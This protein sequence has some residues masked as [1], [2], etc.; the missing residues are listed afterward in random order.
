MNKQAIF[1]IKSLAE[2]QDLAMEVFRFQAV[3]SPVYRDFIA[4]LSV[5]PERIRQIEEIPFLPIEFFKQHQ[6]LQEGKEAQTVFYSSG[7]GGGFTSRHFVHDPQLYKAS[8]QG[9]FKY[10]YGDIRQYT[11]LALLPS[12]LEREGSSLIYMVDAL[13]Q[14]AGQDSGYFLHEHER[15]YELLMQLQAKKSPTLLLGVS[16]ALLDFIEKHTLNFPELIVMETGGMK[17]KRKE[18]IKAELHDFIAK[19][20]GVSSIHAEYGMTELLSQA[21][22]SGAG[23]Y[24]CPPWMQVYIRDLND[25][26]SLIPMGQTGGVN[27]IDLANL[28]SCAF[29]ATQDL[30][31]QHLD[32]SFEILGRFDH[33]DIRGCNLMIN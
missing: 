33:S 12:Y 5:R 25:P 7:T 13:L 10:F 2:F 16:Y 31:I 17:G 3:H 29:I 4:A 6:V 22:S 1:S 18:I 28:H 15:L 19:G 14:E 26:L 23:R 21:Y 9:A 30:G 32:G 20:F 11:L 24:H 8:F 27:I